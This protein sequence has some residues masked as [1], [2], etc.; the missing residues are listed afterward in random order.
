MLGSRLLSTTLAAAYRNAWRCPAE[1]IWRESRA[2]A[3]GRAARGRGENR[4]RLLETPAKKEQLQG[5]ETYRNTGKKKRY[6]RKRLLE[7][8]AKRRAKKKH[9]GREDRPH[10]SKSRQ[11]QLLRLHCHS[12]TWPQ[13]DANRHGGRTICGSSLKKQSWHSVQEGFSCSGVCSFLC[14][15]G[16]WRLN[17]VSDL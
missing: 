5:K 7:T 3:V 11:E 14:Y 10:P 9:G 12:E 15:H 8:P 1:E 6:L 2:L 17:L 16:I 13:L 4:G